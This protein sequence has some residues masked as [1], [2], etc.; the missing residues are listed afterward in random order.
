MA[1][2]SNYFP[3]QNIELF[4]Q[5]ESAVGA[6]PDDN[7]LIKLQC[8]S[9]S[10]P[11]ASVPVEYSGQR[12]GTFVTQASQGRHAEGTKLWTFDTTFKGTLKAVR[13]ATEALF[14]DGG[15][16]GQAQ[17]FNTYAFP[18]TNYKDGESA[19]TFEFRFEN[20]GPDQS[21]NNVQVNGCIATGMSLSQDIGSESGE[22]VCTINWATAYYPAYGADALGGTSVHDT[23]TARNIRNLAV[24]STYID[25]EELV[26]QG[27]ELSCSRTIERIHYQNTTSGDYK[28][29]GYVMTGGFEVTGSITAV[30]N[31]DIH[32][33]SAKF[34]DSNTCN[35][36]IGQASGFSVAC[37]KVFINESTVDNGGAVL[38]QTIPFT[39]VAND[40]MSSASQMLSI[41][42]A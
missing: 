29:F 31:D 27:W 28:P 22:L 11:E 7:D 9:F 36:Q 35:L 17:L 3:S 2:A 12:A 16:D 8:T 32:D 26:V 1:Q 42:I 40:D 4:Y 41:S 6:S 25:S 30:R 38:M 34:R 23:D 5:K 14:E 19:N 10:I 15:S 33:L 20:A 21:T 13:L 24:A 37:P 39:V 18:V